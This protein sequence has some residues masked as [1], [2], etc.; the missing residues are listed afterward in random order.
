MTP[1][2]RAMILHYF[3]LPLACGALLG[4]MLVTLTCSHGTRAQRASLTPQA[5]ALATLRAYVHSEAR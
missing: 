5:H 2:T 3:V 4:L 1:E